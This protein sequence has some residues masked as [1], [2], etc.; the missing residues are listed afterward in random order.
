M[1][2]QRAIFQHDMIIK[3]VFNQLIYLSLTV[4]SWTI[5]RFFDD[6]LWVRFYPILS[7]G[8]D[9]T[10]RVSIIGGVRFV[11]W[12]WSEAIRDQNSVE[13]KMVMLMFSTEHLVDEI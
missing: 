10:I 12:A 6:Q 8:T 11:E 13:Y 5:V 3:N 7:M 4:A 2:I 9:Q 1:N